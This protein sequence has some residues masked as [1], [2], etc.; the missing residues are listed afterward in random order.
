MQHMHEMSLKAFTPTGCDTQSSFPQRFSCVVCLYVSMR[1]ILLSMSCWHMSLVRPYLQPVIWCT[2]RGCVCA[3]AP[4]V[5]ASCELCLV[6]RHAANAC[7]L[8]MQVAATCSHRRVCVQKSQQAVPP[9]DG[10][11]QNISAAVWCS[12]STKL[13]GCDTHY[14]QATL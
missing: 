5:K 11:F 13:H 1:C 14:V 6:T 2:S 9:A 10:W 12:V 7:Y 3:V 8:I 4:A